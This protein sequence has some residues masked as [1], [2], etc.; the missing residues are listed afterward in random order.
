MHRPELKERHQFR[1]IL[2]QLEEL[3]MLTAIG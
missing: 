1:K 2:L 3:P